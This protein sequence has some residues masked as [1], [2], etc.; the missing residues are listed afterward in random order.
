MSL[1]F[2]LLS[3]QSFAGTIECHPQTLEGYYTKQDQQ[4]I[5]ILN[6]GALSEVRI[7]VLPTKGQDLPTKTYEGT[8]LQVEVCLPKDCFPRCKAQL[9]KVIK[10]L[11]PFEVP[12]PWKRPRPERLDER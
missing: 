6:R 3:I 12:K 9:I 7:E 2:I 10:A 11:D 5:L 8:N 1:I 4:Q